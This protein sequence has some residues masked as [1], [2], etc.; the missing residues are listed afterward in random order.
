M[1]S[2]PCLISSVAFD[3]SLPIHLFEILI[4]PPPG[5]KLLETTILAG[6]A[7]L[8]MEAVTVV[9]TG[10]KC[11]D[12]EE[13]YDEGGGGGFAGALRNV[14]ALLYSESFTID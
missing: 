13:E 11:K 7:G 9:A 10:G 6:G 1:H 3:L 14:N 4:F 8:T 5:R 12:D 2:I